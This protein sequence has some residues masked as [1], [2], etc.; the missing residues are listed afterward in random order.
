MKNMFYACLLTLVML[1]LGNTQRVQAQLFVDTTYTAEQMVTDFFGGSDCVSIA[2]IT[3]NG[4]SGSLGFFDSGASNAGLATGLLLTSGLATNAIG[5]NNNGSTSYA[6]GVFMGDP[7]LDL[8][9][10][11][12]QTVESAVLEFDLVASQPTVSFQY[13]FGSEEYLEYVGSSF[14]DVFGFFIAPVGEALQNIALIPDTTLAVSINNVNNGNFSAYYINNELSG[15]TTAIQY[16]GMTTALTATANVTP[17]QTYH[18][19]IAVADAGDAVLDSGVF[20]S[21]ASLCG[22]GGITPM[23]SFEAGIDGNTVT[24]QNDARYGISYAWNFGDGTTSNQRYPAPHTYAN[25]GIYTITLDAQNH[26]GSTR[27]TQVV[28]IGDI[29]NGIN[30]AANSP[31]Q[32]YPNP[33]TNGIVNIYAPAGAALALYD[34]TGKV[35]ATTTADR[36]TFD[37]TPYGKGLYLVTATLNNGQVYTQKVSY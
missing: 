13:V 20:L 9:I 10:P 15:D 36:A 23:G 14:N 16:D 33:T 2:N 12:Y 32:L 26:S 30:T 18:V 29:A 4:A 1:L 5:P 21:T 3:Y 6:S 31:L 11:G 19:K 22:E 27:F 17:G 8:L 37:L 25:D 34:L 24:V 35:L 28:A 7:D